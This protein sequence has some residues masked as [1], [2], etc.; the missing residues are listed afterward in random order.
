MDAPFVRVCEA[1]S[2]GGAYRRVVLPGA[3]D[4]ASERFAKLEAA[5][6]EKFSTARGRSG[7]A[8]GVRRLVTLVRAR[9][10]LEIADQ[11]DVALLGSGDELRVTFVE[12]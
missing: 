7:E 2:E 10:N 5:V 6:C 1:G 4:P 3:A 12:F 8:I 11:E 9:D